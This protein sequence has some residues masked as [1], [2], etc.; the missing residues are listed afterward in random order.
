MMDASWL[1]LLSHAATS[2]T[3]N[4]TRCPDK[5]EWVPSWAA[6]QLPRVLRCIGNREDTKSQRHQRMGGVVAGRHEVDTPANQRW[7][8]NKR[9]EE[10]NKVV[11]AREKTEEDAAGVGMVA[12]GWEDEDNK[13]G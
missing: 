7:C 10:E 12:A 13:T 5:E 2:A 8:R 9:R 1:M 3:M 4:N 11:D 6:G